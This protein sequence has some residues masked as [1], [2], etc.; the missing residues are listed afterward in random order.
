MTKIKDRQNIAV[1][2][3]APNTRHAEQIL[4]RSLQLSC[5]AA[6]ILYTLLLP[7]IPG[8]LCREVVKADVAAL[9]KAHRDLIEASRKLWYS[10]L[11]AFNHLLYCPGLMSEVWPEMSITRLFHRYVTYVPCLRVVSACTHWWQEYIHTLLTCTGIM[12]SVNCI[13]FCLIYIDS[14]IAVVSKLWVRFHARIGTK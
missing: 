9:R 3:I 5:L 8:F 11:F 1:G 10:S 7:V 13:S 4:P 2:G 12:Q 6:P 14:S